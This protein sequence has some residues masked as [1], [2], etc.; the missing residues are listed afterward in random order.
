LVGAKIVQT[1]IDP[2]EEFTG[3]TLE[4]PDGTRKNVWVLS[5]PEGNGSGFLEVG[6][7]AAEVSE[8]GDG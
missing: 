3:F 8:I 7:E 4:M 5:D 1:I 2:D 6:D